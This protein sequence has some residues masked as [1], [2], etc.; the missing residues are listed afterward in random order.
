MKK[1]NLIIVGLW[2]V[3]CVAGQTNSIESRV[4]T[5]LQKMTL[6]EKLDALGGV[7]GF[8]VRGFERLGIPLLKTADSPFG[9][10]RDS[11]ANVMVGGIALAATWN[12]NLAQQTGLQIGRDARSR[13]VHYSLGPGVNIYRS[14]LNGRNFEYFGEDPFLGSRLVVPFIS[15]LQSQGVAATVKHFIGNNSEFWRHKSDSVIDERTMREIYL[16]IFEAAVKEGKTGAVMS[17]YNLVNGKYMSAN[18][19]ISNDILKGD[20]KF[21]GVYMSDWGATHETLGAVNGGLDLEM[22]SGQFMNRQTI[23]PLMKEGKITQATIDDKVRRLLRTAIRFGWLDRP[24]EDFSIPRLN[25]Q[26]RQVALQ[27]ARE[28]IVLLKNTNNLLPFDKS[29]VKNIAVIGPNGHNTP[30]L[31][32]GSATIYP[33]QTVDFLSGISS[34]FSVNA[35]VTFA[36]G[37]SKYN[38]LAASTLFDSGVKAEFFDNTELAGAPV[39]TENQQNINLGKLIETNSFGN[40]AEFEAVVVGDMMPSMSIFA[41]PKPMSARWTGDFTP[42]ESGEY[43]IFVQQ[44]GFGD[45]NYRLYV[46]GKLVRDRWAISAAATESATFS[47]D[48]KPRKIVFEFKASGGISQH[49]VRLGIVKK[50]NWA[51]TNAVELAR[52][53]DVVIVPVGFNAGTETENF[54]RTFS[55]PPG[56]NELIQQLAA[57]NKNVIVVINSGGAVDMSLWIDKVSGV[58]QAW[59]AGQEGGTALA[60][61]LDG[62][63]NPSGRLPATFERRAE[64]NPTFS[65]YYPAENS[66]KINYKESVFVGYRGYEKNNVAPLFPFG[67]GLSYTTFDYKNLNVKSLNDGRFEV[68]FDV[69]NTGKR[70]GADVAQIYVGSKKDSK[71]S[72]PVKELKGFEKVFLKAGESKKVSVVLDKRAF[73][74][75]DV[76][77]KN[78]RAEAG[79]YEIL[80]GRSSAEIVLRGKAILKDD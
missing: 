22:P 9:A 15:G 12:T 8:D 46:D 19:E 57:V 70:D 5:I 40:S 76:S 51:E 30:V 45:S 27:A 47:F 67:Y 17:S 18:G 43:E 1:L 28:S 53:A 35:N 60:E 79:D 16:P 49:F 50:T 4:E 36:R 31:G 77:A 68:S 10:R 23:M 20:W 7:N 6:E 14:P 73:S 71:V 25:Q 32:G 69:K 66:N 64:D 59:Y 55:L 42:K 74:Y 61:I 58:I 54:D 52:K 72:R 26:G 48:T 3:F 2:C 33:F 38:N 75:Y 39:K 56:Q 21:D 37:T 11:R 44:A 24:Q 78:W 62:A 65:N 41:S 29:K 80:I 13:G 34:H 63:T